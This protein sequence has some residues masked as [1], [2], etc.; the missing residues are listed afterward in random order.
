MPGEEDSVMQPARRVQTILAVDDDVQ[1]RALV[2]VLLEHVGYRVI[3]AGDAFEALGLYRQHQ[4][5]IGLLL[6]DVMMPNMNGF[7]LA[8]RIKQIDPQLAVI[9]MSGDAGTVTGGM[10]FIA[11]P[12]KSLDLIDT[13]ANCLA[14]IRTMR[15]REQ[16]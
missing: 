8:N 9:F 3:M 15:E 16:F 6:T 1:I 5:S 11:K 10:R 4:S 13:I 2:G 7:D 14:T 12:F